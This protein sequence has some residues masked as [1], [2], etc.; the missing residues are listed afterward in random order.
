MSASRAPHANPLRHV[1]GRVLALRALFGS[2]GHLAPGPAARIAEGIFCRPPR[3]EMRPGELDFL[4]TGTPFTVIVD[5]QTIAA[6]RWGTGPRVLLMHG[7]GS[8]ASRFRHFVPPL[9]E[10]G[11]GVVALDGPGHGRTGGT[12]ASLP[13]FAAALTAVVREVDGVAGAIGH[14]LGGAAL[15]FAMSRGVPP[16]P[17]VTI[18]APA[19]PAAYFDR[20][21]RHLHLPRSVRTRIQRSLEQ[22]F[23]LAWR[24]LHMPDVV[25]RH[26]AP[27]LV[28]HDVDDHDVPLTDGYALADAA[29]R[30]R[31]LE[32]TGLGHRAI[33][34]DRGVVRDA[35]AFLVEHVPR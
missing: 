7:W 11:F 35:V 25:A 31:L 17:A 26:P 8:R 9:L 22:R 19:E 5:G 3:H 15:L 18:S 34:R 24:D 20:F 33:M 10:A 32:T 13:Q 30:G 4:A 16:V 2:I 28:V 21:A 23:R 12:R 14:S 27:L 1:D 6:W 29:P